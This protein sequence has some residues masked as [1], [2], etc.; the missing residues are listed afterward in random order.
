MRDVS[1]FIVYGGGREGLDQATYW[2]Q[3]GLDL[4]NTT[5]DSHKGI[6]ECDTALVVLLCHLGLM[7]EVSDFFIIFALFIINFFN[8]F[9]R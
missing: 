4:V 3:K 9:F 1:L 2:A 6:S 5:R 8:F 7:Q